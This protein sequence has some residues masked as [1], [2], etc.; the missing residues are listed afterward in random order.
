[1]LLRIAQSGS[2]AA[3]SSMEMRTIAALRRKDL[4]RPG[5][6]R[7]QS[8]TVRGR[9]YLTAKARRLVAAQLS[10]DIVQNHGRQ[11]AKAE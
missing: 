1:M 7:Q 3:G 10:P 6:P 8:G 11:M 4:L 5:H 2:I 9:W